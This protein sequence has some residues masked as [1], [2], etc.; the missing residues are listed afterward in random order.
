MRDRSGK[1]TVSRLCHAI[2][3]I[4]IGLIVVLSA[5]P[6]QAAGFRAKIEAIL[7]Y[8]DGDLVYVYP[9]GGVPNP[10][11]C[12]GSNGNYL[13]FKMSRPRAREYL[14]ALLAAQASNRDVTLYH[15][16]VCVD[17]SV[18]VTLRYLTI[19]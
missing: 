4:C 3:S 11:S 2:L 16:E 5:T 7:L 9:V 19:H 17:Q 8:E 12:H 15:G 10:P 13:S 18:S 1:S 14:S 6:A